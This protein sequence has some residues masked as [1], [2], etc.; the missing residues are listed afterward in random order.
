M[1]ELADK[2]L[3]APMAG[4][5]DLAFRLLCIEHGAYYTTTEMVS[6]KGLHY[7][8]KNTSELMLL[9]N[10]LQ[11]NNN[12]NLV[13]AATINKSKTN[14]GIQI[15]GCEPEIMAE[16]AV[17]ALDFFPNSID[18]NM[19]CPT[20]KIV[21]NGAGAALMKSP[22]LCG[23]IVQA[24]CKKVNIPVTVKIR[25]GW[26]SQNINAVQIAKICENSGASA[27]TVHGRTREQFYLGKS[28]LKIIREVKDAVKIPVIGNGDIYS[29]ADAKKMLDFTGCDKIMVGR[30]SL[31]RPWIFEETNHFF[32]TGQIIPEKTQDYI[33]KEVKKH[34]KLICM[35]KGEFIG[36]K[37]ARKHIAWYLKGFKNAAAFRN[38][39]GSLNT[40]NDFLLLL[41]DIIG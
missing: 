20:P 5:T 15:F 13:S 14:T 9:E 17:K 27:V 36:M 10:P 29:A 21:N 6:S 8:S 16:A 25:A 26:D 33:L 39:A 38:R 19:G 35:L 41:N 37:Q 18:I 2:C 22:A 32:K 3:L 40:Y 31:G 12:Y 7:N 28:D 24:V 23:E 11:E 30:G 34:V 1:F 4:V